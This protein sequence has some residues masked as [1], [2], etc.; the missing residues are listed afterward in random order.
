MAAD[1]GRLIPQVRGLAASYGLLGRNVK[2]A[3]AGT[4]LSGALGGMAAGAGGTAAPGLGGKIKSFAGSKAGQVLLPLV[5]GV[6]TYEYLAE[7]AEGRAMNEWNPFKLL[8]DALFMATHSPEQ[9]AQA[10]AG[11]TAINNY[12][13][14]GASTS[15]VR[16]QLVEGT[17]QASVY[18]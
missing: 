13:I 18:D 8:G 1:I 2:G 17:Q 14:Y 16:D 9:V 3:A 12:Y 6:G 15:D 10:Q 5:A 4:A 11:R 7:T